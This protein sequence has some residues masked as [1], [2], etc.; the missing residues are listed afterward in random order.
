M[1]LRCPQSSFYSRLKHCIFSAWETQHWTQ[2]HRHV[3]AALNRRQRSPCSTCWQ[4]P[5]VLR[6]P[7]AGS[8]GTWTPNSFLRSCFSM[9]QRICWCLGVFLT[10]A[11]THSLLSLKRFPSAHFSSL[12]RSLWLAA[13]PPSE[14]IALP[15]FVSPAKLLR[16]K[17]L[18]HS[19]RSL[20][21][22]LLTQG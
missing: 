22:M 18:V 12:W 8:T 13:Q 4:W 9:L 15:S 1:S 7:F 20:I 14:A 17:A 10:R 16:V 2:V 3:S 11:T 6:G 21:K 19:S 5:P